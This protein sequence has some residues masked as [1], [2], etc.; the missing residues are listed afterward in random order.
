MGDLVPNYPDPVLVCDTV[1][2]GLQAGILDIQLPQS[3]IVD[4]PPVIQIYI[5]ATA[6]VKV[7]AAL[8]VSAANPPAL[9]RKIDVSSG[10]FSASDFYDL[11][12][13]LRFYQIE[14]TANTGQ[15]IVEAGFG[16]L[17]RMMNSA[18]QG[19]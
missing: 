6:T 18:A 12:P 11:I 2:T 3:N 10:G 8:R 4:Y 13:G 16:Q 9:I 14:V 5:S 15:V 7:W 19:T 17:L 1:S